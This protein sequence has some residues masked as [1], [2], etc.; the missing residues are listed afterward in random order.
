MQPIKYK[1]LRTAIGKLDRKKMC[2]MN[3]WDKETREGTK[4]WVTYSLAGVRAVIKI[5][6]EGY[7]TK[8][9]AIWEEILSNKFGGNLAFWKELSDT[10]EANNKGV[11]AMDNRPHPGIARVLTF[12]KKHEKEANKWNQ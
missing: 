5:L 3:A 9:Q 10:Y 12:L 1:K 11:W 6:I 4:Y 8:T 2:R 7:H